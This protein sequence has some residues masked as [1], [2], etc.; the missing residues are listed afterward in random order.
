MTSAIEDAFHFITRCDEALRQKRRVASQTY[1]DPSDSSNAESASSSNS[2]AP[3]PRSFLTPSLPSSFW[4]YTLIL[5]LSFLLRVLVS[6]GSYSG[7]GVAGGRLHGDYEAQR[8]WMEVTT[9]L[10]LSEWYVQTKDNDLQYWGLDYPPLTAYVSWICGKAAE[11]VGLGEMVALHASRGYESDNGKLFMRATVWVTDA[12]TMIPAVIMAIRAINAHKPRHIQLLLA[13]L[14]LVQPAFILIDHGHF[15]YNCFSLGMVAFAVYAIWRGRAYVA[16]ICFV[17]SLTFKQMSLYYAPAFFCYLL[18]R[19]SR[20]KGR[21]HAMF[22]T[23]ILRVLKIGLVVVGSFILCF[24]PFLSSTSTLL[25]VFHRMFPFARGL[26][27]D[28]VSNFWCATSVLIK[29]HLL[30]PRPTMLKLCAATTLLSMAPSCV[31]VLMRPSRRAFLYTLASTATSFYLFSYQVHEKSILLP[32]LPVALMAGQHPLIYA[33]MSIIANFSMYPLLYKDGHSLSYLALQFLF[34]MQALTYAH[35]TLMSG[36]ESRH[37]ASDK[38]PSTSSSN[39][40]SRIVTWVLQHP[41]LLFRAVQVS[42][43]GVIILHALWQF[44]PA[45]ARYPDLWTLLLVI[46][47]AAHFI[48]LHLTLVI[49]QWAMS[50]DEVED[51]DMRSSVQTRSKND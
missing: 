29:W 19:S 18:A 13:C 16:S 37:G 6:G 39:L 21:N 28:K 4:P 8:H 45:P 30:I 44:A 1:S 46:Y 50:M 10:P 36:V 15:Q 31:H 42:L 35:S 11:M 14:V 26:Y 43:F 9:Q 27:E 5:F 34:A 25:A 22:T 38:A 48:L 32:L 3:S 40:A 23:F 12:L 7:A 49:N 41:I 51:E 24:L 20:G 33:W 47:S 17:L 2:D